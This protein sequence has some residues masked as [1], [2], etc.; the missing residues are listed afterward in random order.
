[1]R[2]QIPIKTISVLALFLLV[3]GGPAALA[4][5]PVIAPKPLRVG[6]FIEP[7]FVMD[8]PD[9]LGGFAVDL[10]SKIATTQNW[11]SNYQ[12]VGSIPELLDKLNKG[13]LDIGV[14]DLSITSA[15][16]QLVDFTQPYLDAGL[17]VMI[18]EKHRGGFIDLI[19]GL[20]EAGHLQVFAAGALLLL[21]ATIFLTL[22]NRRLDPSFHR[23][24]T[25]GLSESFYHVVSLATAGRTEHKPILSGATGN[26]LAALWLVCGVT[27]VAYITSSI[28][29][30]M[31]VNRIHSQINGPKDLTGKKVGTVTGSAAAAYCHGARLNVEEF[32]D[33]ESAVKALTREQIDAIVYNSWTLR[34]IDRQH[35][36]LPITEV[37]PLFEP[38]KFGFALP[39]GSPL[40]MP[41]NLT[42][43]RLSEGGYLKQIGAQ[44]F[45]AE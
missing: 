30:V 36:E 18:N 4:A 6:V 21:L 25:M 11:S 19:R 9:G 15:R 8:G 34:Y 22:H 1:M 40:R 38:R 27:I 20:S 17:Q 2:T 5:D 39:Q 16:L 33:V 28:T 44:Y 41:I 10:W 37:G 43:L 7:P 29:S 24:W 12:Q 3:C 13:E 31:T 26:L 42:L 14:T 45:G 32:P 23:S 35:P